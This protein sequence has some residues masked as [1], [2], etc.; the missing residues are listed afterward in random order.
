VSTTQPGS[1]NEVY[2]RDIVG[3]TTHEA[4]I[5]NGGDPGSM[6]SFNCDISANGRYIVFDSFSDNLSTKDGPNADV[7]LR[8]VTAGK[9]YLA[10]VGTN[11]AAADGD[12]QFPAVSNSGRFV[13]FESSATN[14]I[15]NDG[16]GVQDVF[17]YDRTAK[18]NKRLSVA[19]N[20]TAANNA[21]YYAEMSG[22]GS[23]TV[24]TSSADNLVSNDNNG[25]QDVFERGPLPTS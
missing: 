25:K 5:S 12:S 14:L 11:G 21:S 22:D 13:A 2:V 23:W 6:N 7:F 19:T 16:N 8:D 9:T 20:G 18:V 17:R 4:S 10:S 1:V 3:H 15:A 24:F